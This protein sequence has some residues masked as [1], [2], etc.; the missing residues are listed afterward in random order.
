MEETIQ[1]AITAIHIWRKEVEKAES[2][3]SSYRFFKDTD[4]ALQEL[5]ELRELL[6]GR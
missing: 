6:Y 3:R 2:K 1:I 5:K 4:R